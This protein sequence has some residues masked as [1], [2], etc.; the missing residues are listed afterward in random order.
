MLL[1]KPKMRFESTFWTFL[2]LIA[3]ESSSSTTAARFLRKGTTVTCPTAKTG[4][5]EGAGD[6]SSLMIT[7]NT[8]SDCT[9]CRFYLSSVGDDDGKGGQSDVLSCVCEHLDDF[10]YTGP[11]EELMLD[12]WLGEWHTYT[13]NCSG[14][15]SCEACCKDFSSSLDG[16]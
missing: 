15:T 2:L 12:D 6:G 7:S 9:E 4:P 11:E 13:P 1:Q 3:V 14:Y 5:F 10:T 16:E 8:S